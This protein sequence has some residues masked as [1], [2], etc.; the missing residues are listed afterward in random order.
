MFGKF[1][2]VAKAAAAAILA[3]IG[4]ASGV[5]AR[6]V[7]ARSRGIGRAPKRGTGLTPILVRR[8]SGDTPPAHRQGDRECARRRR[9]IASGM[10]KAENRGI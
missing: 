2:G 5:E 3:A 10:L 7:G 1:S 9:Q 6:Y 8:R 4:V